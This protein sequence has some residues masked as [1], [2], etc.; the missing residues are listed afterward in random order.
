LVARMQ[1]LDP[2]FCYSEYAGLA[3]DIKNLPIPDSCAEKIRKVLGAAKL[4]YIEVTGDD[5]VK[6]EISCMRKLDEA[7]DEYY[8]EG[9]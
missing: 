2:H 7:L 8:R 5:F 4:P 6:V 3:I 9:E 1:G